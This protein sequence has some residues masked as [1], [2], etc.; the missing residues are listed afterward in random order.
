MKK[1]HR[2]SKAFHN[3]PW[4]VFSIMCTDIKPFSAVICNHDA[5]E[6]SSSTAARYKPL[7]LFLELEKDAQSCDHMKQMIPVSCFQE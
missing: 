7:F 2:S 3:E 5:D 4:K 6:D 1:V